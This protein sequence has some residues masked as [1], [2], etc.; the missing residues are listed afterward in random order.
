MSQPSGRQKLSHPV[1][2]ARISLWR[3]VYETGLAGQTCD[4]IVR[5]RPVPG[6]LMDIL[7]PQHRPMDMD[8]E[9]AA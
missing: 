2:N 1:I 9:A 5:N 6:A 4:E 7:M 3:M 8:E